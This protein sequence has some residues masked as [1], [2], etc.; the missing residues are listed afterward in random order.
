MGSEMCIRDRRALCQPIA[1]H[2]Y[3]GHP[4]AYPV[5]LLLTLVIES[6]TYSSTSSFQQAT[7]NPKIRLYSLACISAI[8][9]CALRERPLP[10]PFR[11]TMPLSASDGSDGLPGSLSN[12]HDDEKTSFSFK[13]DTSN[14][15]DDDDE[16]DD[17]DDDDEE[18]EKDQ[19]NVCLLY[20]SP[21]PRDRT[22][23][24]MPS[25]A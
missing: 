11:M 17:N 19:D 12:L 7:H 21:S 16:D 15:D 3:S 4:G 9:G 5:H 20:T 2:Q 1:R 18:D 6:P 10:A 8:L 25:S 14:D 22:R 13:S 24:R 23:S